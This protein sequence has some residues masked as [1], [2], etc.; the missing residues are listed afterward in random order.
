VDDLIQA[1]KPVQGFLVNADT[2]LQV[3]DNERLRG[4]VS[5]CAPM[6]ADGQSV[7]WAAKLLG[8]RLPGRVAGP[9][10]FDALLALAARKAYSVYL[11]GA[12]PG[13]AE[14]AARKAVALHPG[15]N[16]AGAH[17]G[18]FDLEDVAVVEAV[19]RAHPD[20]LFVGMPSPRK[21]YWVSENLDRLGVPFTLGVGGTLDVIA[22][23]TSRAPMW[24]QRTGLEWVY[25]LYQE[26]RRMWK[27]YLVGNTRFVALMARELHERRR[28]EV[29]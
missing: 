26:P 10:L 15:L 3:R 21:E 17:H 7:V 22:G 16:I 6:S 28:D 20:M 18:Y 11:L 8:Q 2:L 1:G 12:K 27:R 29:S 9:D 14:E 25:R 13:V 24:M 19:Q 4:I 23:V 5:R